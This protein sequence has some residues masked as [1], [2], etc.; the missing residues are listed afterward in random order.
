MSV[1]I[2]RLNSRA[3]F[4][5]AGAVA[6]LVAMASPG[7]AGPGDLDPAFGEGDGKVTTNLDPV[8][9]DAALAVAIQACGTAAAVMPRRCQVSLTP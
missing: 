5:F 3:V 9:N 1:T 8:E 7:V 2:T 4:P 6:F